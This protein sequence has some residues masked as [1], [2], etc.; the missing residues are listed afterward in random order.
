VRLAYA[1][2]K[3]HMPSPRVIV[4][5]GLVSAHGALV[6]LGAVLPDVIAPLVAGTVYLPLWFLQALGL[7]VLGGGPSGGWA[8]PNLLGWL[9]AAALWAAVWW[10]VAALAKIR[11]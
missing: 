3:P 2:G 5:L 4:F 1:S 6:V 7:P 9:L 11:G 8:G 10:Y